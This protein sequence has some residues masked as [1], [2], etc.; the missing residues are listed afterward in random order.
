MAVE[1][2]HLEGNPVAGIGLPKGT[3]RGVR[4]TW[5]HVVALAEDIVS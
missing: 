4:L 5:K 1:D 3:G 2:G